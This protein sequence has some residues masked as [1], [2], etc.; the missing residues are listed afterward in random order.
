MSSL[1]RVLNMSSIR[2][3]LFTKQW[4]Q[5]APG[6]RYMSKQTRLTLLFTRADKFSV[7]QKLGLNRV[8]HSASIVVYC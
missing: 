5:C 3:T 8:I 7:V 4:K 1:K 6:N 2:K